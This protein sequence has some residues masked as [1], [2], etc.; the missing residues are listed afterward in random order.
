MPA[1][2]AA[3]ACPRRRSRTWRVTPAMRAQ[4][5]VS[6]L[7]AQYRNGYRTCAAVP[8]TVPNALVAA[9]NRIAGTQRALGWAELA[10]KPG[11]LPGEWALELRGQ[12][13]TAANDTNQDFAPG[14]GLVNLRW[15]HELPLGDAGTLQTLV[16]IDNLADRAHVG[17]VIVNDGNRRFFEP[18]APRSALVSLRW[19]KAF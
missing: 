17:S 3:L 13:R 18:G 14:F 1:S 5:A 11:A 8:C 4:L 19:N 2:S 12:A 6:V 10:W 7:Q 16:R 15:S 9:G